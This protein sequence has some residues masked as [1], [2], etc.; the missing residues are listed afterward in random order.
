PRGADAW[1][2]QRL[3]ANG[4]SIGAPPDAYNMKGQNWGLLPPNPRA[5]RADAY[6]SMIDVLRANMRMAGALR[7]DHVL[8]LKRLFWVP[9][10]AAPS[11]GIYIRYPFDDLLGVVA[12]ESVRNRCLVIGEDLGTVPAGFREQMNERGIHSY[13]VLYFARDRR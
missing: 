8:A 3:L 2:M 13:E 9:E 11:N 1:A 5:L 6:Q 12:L 10:G 4:W 7:I